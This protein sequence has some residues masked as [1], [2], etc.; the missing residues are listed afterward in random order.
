MIGMID[1]VAMD[2]RTETRPAAFYGAVTVG[3]RGQIVVPRRLREELGITPGEQLL[4][5]RGPRPGSF[6]VQRAEVLLSE[7]DDARGGTFPGE[8]PR[9]STGTETD[10]GALLDELAALPVFRGLSP[11]ALRQVASLA[12]PRHFDDGE[13]IVREAEPS[14]AM[15]V[16]RSGV[17]RRLKTSTDGK[18]QVLAL[19]GA[20]EAFNEAPIFDGGPNP[21]TAQSAGPSDLYEFLRDDIVALMER[22]PAVSIGLTRTLAARLRHLTN[23]IENLSFRQVTGRIAHLILDQA[24]GKLPS[25]HI[26]QQEMASIVGTAR[27]VAGRALHTLQAAGAID[28]EQGRAVIRDRAKLESF[29]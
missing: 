10:R 25:G 2:G 13:Q 12:R 24:D 15:Y 19:L 18:E 9:A 27:E 16:I 7:A 20:G 14:R 26:T 21:A 8:P 4:V 22:D 6:L 28:L 5:L 1:R 3:A 23:V 17:V 11:A 29:L